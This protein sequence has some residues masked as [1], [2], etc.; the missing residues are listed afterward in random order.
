[1][2]ISS[3]SVIPSYL[4]SMTG[5]SH[6]VLFNTI[7]M[8]IVSIILNILL[9]PKFG[10]LGAAF[11]TA[12]V[13]SIVAAIYSVQTY[14]LLKFVPVRR[15]MGSILLA[16]IISLLIIVFLKQFFVLQILQV[17]FLGGV[18]LILYFLVVI[19]LG[20]LDNNDFLILKMIRNKFKR[21]KAEN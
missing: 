1:M 2:F 16:S 8:L 20:G 13:L 17:I 21:K 6:F 7:I 19:L 11:S 3:F 10:L 9:V 4:I 12:I 14:Y 18:F 15:K 5:K